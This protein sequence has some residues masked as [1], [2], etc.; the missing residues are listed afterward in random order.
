VPP[1]A[2]TGLLEE[3]TVEV[4]GALIPDGAAELRQI[5]SRQ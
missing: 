3:V 1:F 5:L 4:S 2:F